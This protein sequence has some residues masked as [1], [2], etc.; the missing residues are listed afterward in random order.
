MPL[1]PEVIWIQLSLLIEAQA[2]VLPVL[3]DTLPS[4]PKAPK[5]IE[6]GEIEYVQDATPLWVTVKVLSIM[7]IAP[8]R[9][10]AL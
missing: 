9:E 1:A 10:E 2:Q 7:V 3:M 5:A 4:A 6:V 8:V